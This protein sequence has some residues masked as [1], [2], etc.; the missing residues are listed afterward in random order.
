[1]EPSLKLQI[2]NVR[3]S[4]RNDSKSIA[5]AGQL[6]NLVVRKFAPGS[7][8]SPWFVPVSS[9]PSHAQRVGLVYFPCNPCHDPRL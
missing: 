1:M 5:D 8:G 2:R 7:D 4:T 3:R 9:G 6:G